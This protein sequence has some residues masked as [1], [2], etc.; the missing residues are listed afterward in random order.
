MGA[1]AGSQ[2]GDQ[3]LGISKLS[4]YSVRYYHAALIREALN[5]SLGRFTERSHLPQEVHPHFAALALNP[6]SRGAL[7]CK[8]A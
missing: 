2:T 5:T 7:V 3:I 4:W 1:I 6:S 8:N